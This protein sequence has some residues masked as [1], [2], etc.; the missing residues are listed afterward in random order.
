MLVA[1]KWLRDRGMEAIRGPIN[2]TAEC[3]GFLND[4]FDL[5]QVFLSPYNPPYY[6]RFMEDLSYKKVKDLMVYEA[7]SKTGYTIPQRFERFTSILFKRRPELSVRRLNKKNLLDDA[8]A[9]WRITNKSLA[10]NWGY[11]PVSRQVMLDV[12]KKL[13][14]ILDEDA[15]WFVEDKG[16]PV[17]CALGYPDI[18]GILRNM[19]GRLLP[20]GFLKLFFGLKKVTDYRLF[21]LAVLPEYHNLGLDVLLYMSLYKAL[22]PKGVRLEANYILED[23]LHIRNALEKLGMKQIKRYRIY[24]K[25][26]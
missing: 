15:V 18:S 11:V 16:K 26:L 12:V 13:K 21:S 19:R 5:P 17:A 20:F 25:A 6:N 3:W 8:E 22:Q 1:E 4:G 9:I 23:N 2:P 24:E 10:N 14:T 7:D